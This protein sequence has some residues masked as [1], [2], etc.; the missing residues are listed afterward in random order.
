MVAAFWSSVAAMKKRGMARYLSLFSHAAAM[1][2]GLC[3]LLSP[4]QAGPKA[5]TYWQVDD[6]RPGMKG[7]GRTVLKGTQI[8]TFEAEV[9]GILKNT[10]PGRDMILC[11]LAGLNLE[12]TGVIAGMS[13]SPIYIEGKLLG[14][15]AFAWPYG[16]EP[17]AGVTP[18][19]QM[20]GYVESYERR[21]LAEE[22]KPSRV[23]LAAPVTI[24][25]RRYD[26][27]TV[28]QGYTGPPAQDDGLWLMP[29]RM[30]L[31]S[32]GF[33]RHSLDI[34][35]E[36]LKGSGLQPMQGGGTTAKVA[37]DEKNTPLQPG[38]SLAVALI[39]G[40]FDLS[41]IGT[42]THI[43]GNRVYGWGHPFMSLGTCE[44]PLMTGY[45]H[46]VYPRQSISFKIGSPLKAVGVIN[47]DVSTCIAG[48]LGRT[49]EMMPVA[50]TV[51][52]EPGGKTKTFNL[53]MI[54]HR[55]LMSPLLLSALVNSVDMEG[56]LPEEMTAELEAKIDVQG[57]PPIVLK[58]MYSGPSYSGGRAPQGLYSQVT[59][60]ISILNSNPLKPV[61]IKSVECHTQILPGRRTADIEAVELDSST[62]EP[63]DTLKVM[64]F[65]RPYRGARQRM[66][67][68]LKLPADLPEGTYTATI[69]DDLANARAE[70]RDDPTLG[71]P[72]SIEQ[73]FKALGVVTSARRT[74]LVVRVP[75]PAAGVAMSGKSLPS[76]PPS[77]VQILSNSHRSGAQPVAGALVA[78]QPTEWVFQGSETVR[79]TVTKNRKVLER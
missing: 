63:G 76:L 61:H 32:T 56:D 33:T 70:L 31:S 22:T 19:S 10:S 65:V 2:T 40:D 6:V 20:H 18:F 45:V 12:K 59:N 66:P 35:G 51:T 50:V 62:Y 14:A 25:G 79:F 27:V 75:L 67:L 43:E 13:G 4:L 8:E 7:K 9:L 74:N 52:R 42:V 37:D 55:S 21:D 57:L 1:F 77:M 71:S 29:L 38:G 17:I 68:T 23:G 34:L 26:A 48:W 53:E 16:K 54:R 72:Q 44:L 41:A 78:R 58:D 15:V 5:E 28:S 39:R 3:L 64:L 36:G 47:A 69:C 46:T 49:P 30:P 60:V 73:I 11:R 24:E